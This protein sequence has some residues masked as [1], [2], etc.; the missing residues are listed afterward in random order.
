MNKKEEKTSVELLKKIISKL[1]YGDFLI[2]VFDLLDWYPNKI[3][4]YKSIENPG[5]ESG[6]TLERLKRQ[7]LIKI[8]KSVVDFLSYKEIFDKLG[9]I[10]VEYYLCEQQYTTNGII[11]NIKNEDDFDLIIKESLGDFNK[12]FGYIGKNI[13]KDDFIKINNSKFSKMS[14]FRADVFL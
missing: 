14:S 7:D 8:R 13:N 12:F 2:Q 10:S 11:Y 4:L 3:K 6:S 9:S 1:D 5:I